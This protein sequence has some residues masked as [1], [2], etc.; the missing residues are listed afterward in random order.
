MKYGT[1]IIVWHECYVMGGSDWSI[2]D[3]L[4]NW[5]DKDCKFDFFVNRKHEGV[6]LLKKSLNN[7]CNF[8]TYDSIIEKLENLKKKNY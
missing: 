5:P 3:I 1:K 6:K 8:N 7:H 4:T 2:I